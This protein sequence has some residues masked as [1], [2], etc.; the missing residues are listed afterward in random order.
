MSVVLGY[1]LIRL[2]FGFCLY[3]IR[4]RVTESSVGRFVYS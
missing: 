3:Q 4:D 1:I 2:W